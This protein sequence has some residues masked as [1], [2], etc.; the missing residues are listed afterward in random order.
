MQ[1]MCSVVDRQSRVVVRRKLTEYFPEGRFLS[2]GG[3]IFAVAVAVAGAV[4]CCK[5]CFSLCVVASCLSRSVLKN[6]LS[7]YVLVRE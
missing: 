5:S 4:A 1:R 3:G 7:I 2:S 6:G